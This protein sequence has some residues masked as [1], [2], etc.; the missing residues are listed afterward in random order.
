[1]LSILGIENIQ[2]LREEMTRRIDRVYGLTI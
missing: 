1:M 2:T